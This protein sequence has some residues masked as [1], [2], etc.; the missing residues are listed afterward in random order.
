MMLSQEQAD[1]LIAMLK[2]AARQTVFTW[3]QDQR[4]NEAVVAVEDERLQFVLSLKRNPFEIRLH[5]RTRDRDVGL[6][7]VDNNPYHANPDGTEIRN[8]PHLHIYREGYDKLEWAEPIDWYDVRSPVGTL[9]RFLE[10]IHARFT[11]GYQLS[12]L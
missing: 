1:R 12:L 3:E 4:Q 5:F 9:D 10:I 11:F 8:Q 6:V 2:E 7:R